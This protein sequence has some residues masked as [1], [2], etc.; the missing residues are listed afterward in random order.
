MKYFSIHST[1]TQLS[2][3]FDLVYRFWNKSD[4]VN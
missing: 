2:N 3:T 4:I 1:I